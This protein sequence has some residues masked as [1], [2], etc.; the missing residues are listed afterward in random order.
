MDED[1][2]GVYVSSALAGILVVLSLV[3]LP[4]VG[5][6]GLVGDLTQL[7]NEDS[8]ESSAGSSSDGGLL[9]GQ[10]ADPPNGVAFLCDDSVDTQSSDTRLSVEETGQVEAAAQSYVMSA[11]GFEGSDAAAHEQ[12]VE[13]QVVRDCFWDSS[14]GEDTENMNEAVRQGSPRSASSDE[15]I[16]QLYFAEA[17]V[18]FDAGSTEDVT[19]EA[20]GE[21]YLLTEG[22]AVWLTRDDEGLFPREQDLTLVKPKEGG[23]WKVLGGESMPDTGFGTE[24]EQQ[25]EEKIEQLEG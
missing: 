23:E 9:D 2:Q 4:A 21:E 3:L 22:T 10:A 12:G 11:Y 19:H 8:E 16:E 20:S 17:F 7:A 18:L 24:Y 25:A 6:Y 5:Q 15:L 13:Q 1:R 14:P